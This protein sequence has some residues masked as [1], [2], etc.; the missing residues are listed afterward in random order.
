M[1]EDVLHCMRPIMANFESNDVLLGQ[2]C[3]DGAV[4]GKTVMVRRVSEITDECAGVLVIFDGGRKGVV[5]VQ[6]YAGRISGD[7]VKQR[8]GIETAEQGGVVYVAQER[9]EHILAVGFDIER[10]RSVV[11]VL[12][13]FWITVQLRGLGLG[14]DSEIAGGDGEVAWACGRL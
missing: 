1:T 13:L 12:V 5:N 11:V 2:E 7:D 6:R 3:G 10:W 9:G 14:G 4:K 8:L